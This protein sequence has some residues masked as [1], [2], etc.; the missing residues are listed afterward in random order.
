[1]KWKQR[2]IVGILLVASGLVVT[3]VLLASNIS[4]D[5]SK[6]SVLSK[7]VRK[8][9]LDTYRKAAGQ[10]AHAQNVLRELQGKSKSMDHDFDGE[11]SERTAV[12]EW[13]KQHIDIFNRFDSEKLKL[14]E[15]IL[16]TVDTDGHLLAELAEAA[17]LIANSSVPQHLNEKFQGETHL[18]EL[19]QILQSYGLLK[20]KPSDKHERPS[21]K[22]SI[23][24]SPTVKTVFI[25]E[26]EIQLLTSLR[27]RDMRWK[28]PEFYRKHLRLS[29]QK[30]HLQSDLEG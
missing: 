9:N 26:D 30:A 27:P 3:V 10:Q 18:N 15:H 13:F 23:P 6:K 2:L 20:H 19:K 29:L 21:S 1:M 24:S 7:E 25:P 17:Y 5:S 11:D 14:L 16:M 22:K 8:Y 12:H 28:N 4:V